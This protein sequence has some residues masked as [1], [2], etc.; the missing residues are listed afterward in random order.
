MDLLSCVTAIVVIA[1]DEYE[2]ERGNATCSRSL[3]ASSQFGVNQAAA[4]QFS[5]RF[6]SMIKSSH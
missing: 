1:C 5:A 6:F 3:L 2:K 4:E